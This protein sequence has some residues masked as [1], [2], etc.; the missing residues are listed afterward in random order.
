MNAAA[1]LSLP[2]L[3]QTSVLRLKLNAAPS[4]MP[5]GQREVT[6]FILVKKRTPSGP[7]MW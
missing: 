4:R 2:A 6:V 5:D 7:C 3:I 1:I